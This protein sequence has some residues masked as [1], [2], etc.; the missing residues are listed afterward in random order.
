[1]DVVGK[2]PF[3]PRSP[4][5]VQVPPGVFGAGQDHGR[6]AGKR[7]R[8]FDEYDV[9]PR[10]RVQRVEVVKIGDVRQANDGH[11]RAVA[12]SGLPRGLDDHR[13]LRLDADVIVPGKHA[14]HR[15]FRLLFDPPDAVCKQMEV[16]PEPVDDKA[17]D[18]LPLPA[19]KARKGPHDLGEHTALVDVGHQDHRRVCVLGHAKIHDVPVHQVDLRART[20]PLHHHG[21]EACA[22]PVQR[23]GGRVKKRLCFRVVVC[24]RGVF[25]YFSE[26]HHLGAALAG[27]FEQY[28][29]HVHVRGDAGRLGLDDLGPAHFQPFR[30]DPGVVG[31]VLGLERGDGKPPVGKTPAQGCRDDALSHVRSGPQHRQAICLSGLLLAHCSNFLPS[32][33]PNG[34]FIFRRLCAPEIRSKSSVLL[35]AFR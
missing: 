7:L 30:G 32:K 33:K 18:Q 14:E 12:A 34:R 21:I 28:G 31:H 15:L 20:G 24:G 26:Q 27:R 4:E 3:P 13:I 16:S 2:T 29:I 8:R 6:K 5:P 17:F 19:R 10:H 11:G 22:N 25:Q 1:M 23:R 9:K 35:P